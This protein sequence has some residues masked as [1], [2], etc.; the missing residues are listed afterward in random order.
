MNEIKAKLA[1]GARSLMGHFNRI[2]G[3]SGVSV[4]LVIANAEKARDEDPKS[5]SIP[6]SDQRRS[7]RVGASAKILIEAR[8]PGGQILGERPWVKVVEIVG[9]RYKVV[10]DNHLAVFPR[11]NDAELV[12]GSENVLAVI[13][14][15]EYKLPYG[16]TCLVSNSVWE[17]DEWPS[18][19]IRG[20]AAQGDAFSGWAVFSVDESARDARLTVPCHMLISKF[21]VLDTIL[22]E[23]GSSAWKWSASHNEYRHWNGESL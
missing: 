8:L 11:L 20:A 22:D 5:F 23:P 7:L 4:D 19:A 18:H 10:M 1:A 15:D 21:Q 9:S 13:L 12:I 3:R 14:P 17:R 6:R 2:I 16:Q